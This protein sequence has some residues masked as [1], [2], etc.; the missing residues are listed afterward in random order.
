MASAL[1]L[2][3]TAALADEGMWTLD[4]PPAQALR[5][6]Y[7]FEATP[8]WLS[9][10][11]AAAVRVGGASG[12]FVSDAGLVLTNHHVALGC[13]ENLSTAERD[14]ARD[15]FV[16]R[17]RSEE[18]ACPGIEVRR[19]E[20]TMD[21][22][23]A[24]RDAVTAT[25]ETQANAQRNTAIA[26]AER[27]CA[28][29]TGLRCEVITLYRGGAYQ[30]YRYRVWTDVRLVAAPESRIGFFG[31]D[32]D[33][34]VFP[35]YDLDFALL[36]VYADGKPLA[37]PQH[38]RL[39]RTPLAEGDL[40]FAA[41][42][43]YST[44]RDITL[45]QLALDRDVRYPFMMA[46]AKRQRA[47]LTAFGAGSAESKRRAEDRLF[48]TE[49]WLKAMLGEYKALQDPALERRKRADE[50]ALRGTGSDGDPWA[51]IDAAVRREREIFREAWVTGYG[52]RSLFSMAGDLVALARER[53][54][55]DG[56]RLSAYRDS[57]IPRLT[58]RLVAE[59]PVYRDL[60]TVRIADDFEQARETLGPDH[61][62]VRA[63]LGGRS[64]ADAAAALV[65]ATHLDR[66]EERRRLVDGGAAAVDAS[67]DPLLV[68]ARTVYPL[69]RR[70]ARIEEI[71]VETPI[72]RAADA[73]AQ[74][75]FKHL[76]GET[77]PDATGTL[78]LSY[79]T[80]RGYDAD[81]ALTP[82]QTNFYGLYARSAA[83]GNQPPFELPARWR[84]GAREL[85]LSTPLDFVSTLDIIGG[86]SGSPVVNRTGELV[87]LV[88]DGN[89]DSLAWRFGY[90]VPNAR[91]IAV[92]AGAIVEALAKIYDARTLARELAGR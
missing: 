57:A 29:A 74:V 84:E 20:S 90:G 70:L 71:E 77:Y 14:L 88:F 16:A 39:A 28:T 41:G 7:G 62:F 15:G 85:D 30:L 11:R 1:L 59:V 68:V 60:E 72:E 6:R 81:G 69:H 21:V 64:A 4:R 76:A 51:R 19:L 43:P 79:G 9:S 47:L 87:G 61:P 65:D 89:L 52:Y 44:D 2:V 25:D 46:S 73:I 37:T 3:A 55:P 91:A 92:N 67:T 49:N 56:E 48:G 80:V 22:S 32:P 40:V 50:A 17:A 86:N 5:E 35:R 13:I 36:R 34:F 63:V 8:A 24:I 82:W 42:H 54:L 53:A 75:R 78:R 10:L 27:A 18:R 23:S 66:A 45:S 26:T 83:F 38:L 12:S 58:E 31:G 33:N